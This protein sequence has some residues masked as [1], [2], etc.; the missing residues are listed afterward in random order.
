MLSA[1][2]PSFKL[3]IIAATVLGLAMLP[4]V[5]SAQQDND[6][7]SG[8]PLDW[9]HSHVDVRLRAPI[10]G[11]SE[12]DRSAIPATCATSN[13]GAWTGRELRN[14]AN[15]HWGDGHRSDHKH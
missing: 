13:A 1:S 12:K 11:R 15:E 8:F 9:S 14:Y 6:T 7:P 10:L 2:R 3:S 4:S 5:A